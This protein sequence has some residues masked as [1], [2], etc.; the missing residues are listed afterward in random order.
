M[1]TRLLALAAC[2]LTVVLGAGCTERSP[3][4]LIADARQLE[5]KGDS[6]AAAILL[7]NVLHKDPE[8]A[9]AAYLLGV[10]YIKTNHAAAAE[11]ALRNALAGGIDHAQIV[12]HL[13]RSLLMQQKFQ[14]LL[15]ETSWANETAEI[16]SLRG[17]AQLALGRRSDARTTFQHAL[18]L[19]PDFA[20]ALVGQAGL[21]VAEKD[22]KAALGFLESALAAAP[23]SVEAW[24]LKGDLLR[25]QAE[26]EQALAVYGKVLEIEPEH[27]PARIRRAAMLLTSGK[28][29]TAKADIDAVKK[30]MPGSTPAHY[31][32]ALLDFHKGD[33]VAA[34]N[35]IEQVLRATPDHMPSL[36]LAGIVQYSLGG[37]QQSEQ[38]LQR[39]LDR[40][41]DNLT[42]RRFLASAQVK[43]LQGAR[44]LETALPGLKQTPGDR[45]L[46]IVAGEAYLQ[47]KQYPKAIEYLSRAVAVEPKSTGLRTRLGMAHLAAGETESAI[48]ELESAADLNL[49]ASHAATALVLTLLDAKQY[50]RAVAAAL[51]LQ[52][53]DPVTLNL[54]GAA[55]MGK[56]DEA[57]AR[58]SFESALARQPGHAPAVMNLAQLDLAAKNYDS[59]RKRFNSLL[60]KDRK[61]IQAMVGLAKLENALGKPREAVAWLEKA[62]AENPRNVEV[63]ILLAS[64]YLQARA[65]QKAL[66]L[67]SELKAMYPDH[68]DLLVVLGQAQLDSGEKASA[69][70]TYKTLAGKVPDSPTVHYRVATAE[71]AT[72]DYAGA[73]E[74]LRRALRLKP[75]YL[76]AQSALALMEFRA[77]RHVASIKLA[78]QL[79]KSHPKLAVGYSLEG[80]NLVA[81][82]KYAAAEKSYEKAF[83]IAKS[84][85]L[86]VKLHAASIAAGNA[87]QAEPRLQQWL[88]DNP[89]DMDSHLYLGT[90]YINTGAHKAAIQAFESVLQKDAKNVLAL[91]NLASLYHREKDPRALQYF[92]RAHQLMPD[93]AAIADNVGWLLVEQGKIARGLEVLRKATQLAP[94][95]RQIRYH[96][97]FALAKSGDEAR[98][99]E[100]LEKVLGSGD[101]FPQREEARIL[102]N[103]LQR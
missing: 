9:E 76:E 32:Q 7:R 73:T 88:K 98:A 67:A 89:N 12:P 68:P 23:R 90:H 24:L 15:D 84:G 63:G 33:Y 85:T 99:M 22:P 101:K 60:A 2:F 103:R 31:G 52:K 95:D 17:R 55:Y 72:E 38:W 48:R 10:V 34:R 82:R 30:L 14:Q 69:L 78:Q 96:L 20:D 65:P 51:K 66:A 94:Q 62:R 4:E 74:S 39:F 97:A 86:A 46:L 70:A 59:A 80:D 92:E 29:D 49:G 28:L 11:E 8:N 43:T 64:H 18:K 100:E 93:N 40:Y 57:N 45:A 25:S 83:N 27:V 71:M 91:N 19:Q 77:R 102:L 35:S 36:L 75:D 42:A 44:A 21:A 87:R 61:S 5:A 41:P 54:L 16:V 56:K 3:R 81:Q 50:D 47:L 6:R 58:K 79:Q 13:A 53:D 1:T 37:F 26:H